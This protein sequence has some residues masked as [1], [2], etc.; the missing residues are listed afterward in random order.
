M[1]IELKV[2][3]GRAGDHNDLAH[4]AAHALAAAYEKDLGLVAQVIGVP[5][6]ALSTDWRIELPL[7][8][9]A[10]LA[11]AAQIEQVMASGAR[12]LSAIS[13]CA[14][15]LAT[16]PVIARHRPEAVVVW[17]DSHGDLNTPATTTTGYLGGLA[18]AGAAGLWDSGLGR[19]VDLANI[20][21]VGVR[22]LDPSE[23]Q[24][25]DAGAVRAIL[26]RPDMAQELQMAIAG[27]AVYVHLD[28]DVLE[29]GIVPTDYRHICGLDLAQLHAL[30]EVIA[31]SEVVGLEIA[32]LQSAFEPGG[33]AVSPMPLMQALAPLVDKMR[34]SV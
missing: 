27:R 21:L 32:E 10:L 29:P 14:V 16:L 17:F 20:I 25:V 3:Q 15:A 31:Q 18:L 8:M 23:Q 28:C 24:L 5:E 6:P 30:C 2:F 4:P 19:G 26:V 11:M 1:T 13:R 7:A 12:P 33:L 22:D 34:R 9:P